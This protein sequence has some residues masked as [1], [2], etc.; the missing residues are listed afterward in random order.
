M[1]EP[2]G[3]LTN[4]PVVLRIMECIK[5]NGITEKDMM[6]GVGLDKGSL[7]AWKYRGSKSYNRYIDRIA[8]Y[9][10]VSP[11]Y[12]LRGVDKDVNMD[13][14][15]NDEIMLIKKYRSLDHVSKIIIVDVVDNYLNSMKYE[16]ISRITR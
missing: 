3:E 14:M 13:A 7:P 8:D 6:L 16:E 4:D 12:L 5:Q 10:G 11:D 9:L 1:R 15:T 2:K